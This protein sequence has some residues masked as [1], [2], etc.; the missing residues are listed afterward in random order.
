MENR[1]EV[2][3]VEV[4][5]SGI[6]VAQTSSYPAPQPE[7]GPSH[8]LRAHSLTL[9]PP[10]THTQ[11]HGTEHSLTHQVCGNFE[12]PMG[13]AGEEE[14]CPWIPLPHSSS[15]LLSFLPFP[16]LPFLLQSFFPPYLLLPV[17]PLPLAP[18]PFPPAVSCGICLPS[19]SIRV[20]SKLRP[21]KVS[22]SHL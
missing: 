10:P 4:R 7:S 13:G 5:V 20:S 19:V 17:S 21:S 14:S 8:S 12:L 1:R 11:G 2:E 9:P 18:P 16:L 3:E 15:P 6:G 22:S